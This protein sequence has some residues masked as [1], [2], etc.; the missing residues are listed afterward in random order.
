MKNRKLT[1][2][3]KHIICCCAVLT[4]VSTVHAQNLPPK[5]PWLTNSVFPTSHHNPGQTDVSPVAGPVRSQNLTVNDVKTVSTVFNTHPTLRRNGDERVLFLSQPNGITKVLAT[6]E[7]FEQVSY[8]PYPAPEF[9]DM[10][11]KATPA[12]IDELLKKVN[13]AR[14]AY[15]DKALLSL[16]KSI[17]DIGFNLRTVANGGYS[18]IDKDGNHYAVYGGV[19]VLKSTDDGKARGPLRVVKTVDITAAFPPELAKSV[20]RVFGLNM[21]YDGDIAVAAKGM[22]ALLDRDL[23]MKG[24]ITFPGESVDNGIAVDE[25]GI[26]VVTSENMYKVVWT[27]KKLSF[28]EADGGWVSPYDTMDGA[29]ALALGA[30]SGGSG[31]TPT[32]VGYGDDEDKL[33]IISDANENGTNLVAFWRDK[34]PA[35]FKQKPG[36]KSRRIA[37]QIRIDVSYLTIEASSA[38]M[39]YGVLVLNGTYPEP[40]PTP[41]DLF[42]NGMTSGV[43]RMAPRGIQKF[44]WNPEQ[45]KWQKTWM[46]LAIDNTDWMVPVVSAKSKVVYLA[47]KVGLRYE[48]IGLDWET[49]RVIGRWPM[50]ND[51]ALYNGWGGIGYFLDDGDLI[52]GGF[53]SVKRVNF[54]K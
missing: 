11:K 41:A 7:K 34:I 14:R 36:T 37:D 17:S 31:T 2:S 3:I 5:N 16:S 46:D 1:N 18:M 53:F 49:G 27:G 4:W 38:A 25:S 40:S 44:D 23:A 21:T 20:S 43:T 9:E 6:G 22:I 42:G 35:D 29:K 12:A 48:Y 24:Y 45:N 51:S 33:V 8:L 32:L 52:Y 28:A 26:Y 13:A 50:P 30:A 15:D 39:G 10:A 47:N 54:K 19:N